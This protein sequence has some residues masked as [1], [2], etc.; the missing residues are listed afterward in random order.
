M[1]DNYPNSDQAAGFET[2]PKMATGWGWILAY[3]LL[4]VAIGLVAWVNPVATGLATGII[5]AFLLFAYG[6]VAIFVGVAAFAGKSRWLELLAGVIAI[7]AALMVAFNPFAGAVTLVWFIGAWLVVTGVVQFAG[8]FSSGRD[9]GWRIALGVLDLVLGGVLLFASP[10]FALA[11]LA[12]AIGISFVF[13]GI[14]LI[15]LSFTMRKAAAI[16]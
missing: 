5:I 6:V 10:S 2:A 11:F 9:R 7:I 4:V 16:E 3:G 8:A 1:Q 14:F 13:R 12:V 15:I